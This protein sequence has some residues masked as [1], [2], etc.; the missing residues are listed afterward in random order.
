MTDSA[1]L[2]TVLGLIFLFYALA[3]LCSG[4]V[5][6][7]ANWV[8]KRAKYLLRGIRDLLDDMPAKE[9][10]VAE[11]KKGWAQNTAE[12]VYLNSMVERQRYGEMLQAPV[13]TPP[14]EPATAVPAGAGSTA[15]PPEQPVHRDKITLSDVMGH[16]LVQPFRHATSLGKP[17]RNPSYLPSSVFSRTLVDLLTPG[18][19]EPEF[20]DI[21]RGVWALRSSPKLRQS[22]SSIVKAANGEVDSFLGATQMWFDRQMDRVTGSYKRW[23]K[24]WVLVLAVAV[25]C[26]GNIDS[27]AIA[28]ALY[29][30]GATRATVIQQVTD[31]NFCSTPGDPTK[32]AE[33]AAN[34]LQKS[35]IPLGWSAPNP[36][37]GIWGWPLKV[38]GL[39]LSVGAAT[40][41]APFWYRLLDRIGSLRNTGRPPEPG[42]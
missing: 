30:G 37:D 32:C 22:L 40:L 12:T 3:L 1:V 31:L 5:E 29:A 6:M 13:P 14:H 10:A 11:K 17:T 2:D 36:Q 21:E 20:A 41:G 33:E 19:T 7:I 27:I 28:R 4:L 9:L 8:K 25:V 18:S 16:A 26:L 23:A 35:V 38:I 39:L 42:S 34:F 15:L 24:R